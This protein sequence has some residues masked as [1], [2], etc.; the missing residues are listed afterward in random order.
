MDKLLNLHVEES[1]FLEHPVP[2][3]E[4]KLLSGKSGDNLAA[5]LQTG[6]APTS[7][8]HEAVVVGAANHSVLKSLGH[9]VTEFARVVLRQSTAE[10]DG[11][12]SD[13]KTRIALSIRTQWHETHGHDEASPSFNFYQEQKL[14]SARTP[15]H[16]PPPLPIPDQTNQ[17]REF[18]RAGET[19]P[20]EFTP[21]RTR[22]FPRSRTHAKANCCRDICLPCLG[23]LRCPDCCDWLLTQQASYRRDEESRC[24]SSTSSCV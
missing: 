17:P 15:I 11:P 18:R 1:Q 20:T 14:C 16:S 12:I 22:S 9:S 4:A 3:Q 8:Q 7:S 2:G 24:D 21:I 5:A 10:G 6:L 19:G 13:L 23:Q